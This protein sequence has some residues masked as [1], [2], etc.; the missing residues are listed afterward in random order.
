[1]PYAIKHQ[2]ARAVLMHALVYFR[3]GKMTDGSTEVI[4]LVRER[5]DLLFS[6]GGLLVRETIPLW[7]ELRVGHL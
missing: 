4:L 6:V 1:M 7:I 2:V 3:S 5:I